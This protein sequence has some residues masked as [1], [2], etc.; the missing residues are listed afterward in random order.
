MAAGMAGGSSDGAA[1]LRVLRRTLA[2]DLSEGD[3]EH[4]ALQVG[5]DVP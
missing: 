2:P 3:L 4:F 5:S 1:V